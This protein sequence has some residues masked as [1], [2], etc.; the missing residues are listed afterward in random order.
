MGQPTRII[1]KEEF[2]LIKQFFKYD[3]ESGIIFWIKSPR[4]NIKVNDIAGKIKRGRVIVRFKKIDYYGHRLAW[5]IYN[6]VENQ[7]KLIDHK[8]GNPLD[9]SIVNLREATYAINSQNVRTPTKA[10]S[11]GYL[12]VY[13]EGDKFIAKIKLNKKNI[14]LGL[15]KNA[16]EASECYLKNKRILHEGCTI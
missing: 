16:I 4:W 14:R 1:E 6:G 7:P 15:F 13:P 5:L 10:S 3:P 9:N 12:G 11:T 2:D 8:N